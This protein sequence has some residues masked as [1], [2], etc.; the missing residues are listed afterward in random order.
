MKS[1]TE[2][3]KKPKAKKANKCTHSYTLTLSGEEVEIFRREYKTQKEL[4]ECL[5]C[6]KKW[7]HPGGDGVYG[8]IVGRSGVH[9]EVK[10]GKKKVVFSTDIKEEALA[11]QD[12]E[13]R[14]ESKGNYFDESVQATKGKKYYYSCIDW[15]RYSRSVELALNAPFDP[16]KLF[17]TCRTYVNQRGIERK[18]IQFYLSP[19]DESARYDG[20]P[21]ADMAK[22][23]DETPCS[24]DE[25][26]VWSLVKGVRKELDYSDEDGEDW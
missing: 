7:D 8:F 22:S 5:N 16:Q 6:A 4:D 24:D 13:L 17:L 21:V 12:G 18:F 10:E 1:A 2:R 15:Y 19:G 14:I 3:A 25:M 20:R 26:H 11:K 9:L 23:I